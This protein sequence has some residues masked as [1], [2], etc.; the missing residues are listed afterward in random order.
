MGDYHTKEDDVQKIST[1]IYVT[2]FPEQFKARD[3]WRICSQ[4][5]TVIDAFIPNKRSKSGYRFG[6]VCFIRIK[7]VDILV[8]NLYTIWAVKIGHESHSAVKD[9]KPAL[10]LDDSCI[11][12]KDLSLSVVGWIPD[13]NDCKEDLTDSDD[14]SLCNKDK[15]IEN[16]E[17]SEVDSDVDVILKTIFEQG[18]QGEINLSVTKEKSKVDLEEGHF[19]DPFNIY[20]LLNKKHPATGEKNQ[21]EGEPKY[22]PGFTPR[23]VSEVNSN[24]EYN[25][26][27]K[28]NESTQKRQDKVNESAVKKKVSKINSKEDVG[29][30]VSLGHFK[31]V[32]IPKSGGFILQ[33][34]EDLVNVGQTMGYKM[35]GFINNIE[36]IETKMEQVDLFNIKSC[37]G[38]FA[39]DYVVSPSVGNSGGILCVWDPTMFHK[40]HSTVSDYFIAI[41]GKWAPNDKKLLIILVYA[42][43]ELAEKK[44]LRQYLN[45]IINRWKGDVIVM[46]D[47]NEVRIQEERFGS[48][49]NAQRV[50]AFNSFISLGGLVEV[51]SGG[52]LFTW[53]HKSASKMSKLDCFLISEGLMRSCPN[54][55][56][57]TL[58]RYLSDHRPIVLR[59]ISFDYGPTLFC[60]YHYW[61]E[62]DGFDSFVAATWKNIDTFDLNPMLRLLKKL[63]HF[64]GE[65]RLWVKDKNDKN[66]NHKKRLKNMLTGI[67][68]S[69]DKGDVSS[70]ILEERL[71]IMHKLSDLENMVSLELAQKAKIKWSIEGDE[72]SKFFHGIYGVSM[73]ALTKDHKGMKLNTSSKDEVPPKSKN[74][75]PL[76]DKMDDLN[77]TMEEYIRLEEEKAQKRGKVFNWELLSMLSS[78]TLSREPTVSSLNDEIDF[79][80]SFDDSD[81]EDYTPT[82]SYLDDLDFFKEFENEF[83]AIVYDDA[84]TSK[85]DLLTEPI[86]SP[87]H[88]DEFDLND[89]T[90]LS[91]YG[92]EEQNIL[93]FNDLFPLNIIHPDDL[94]SEKDNDNNEIDIIQSSEGNEIIQGSNAL[95]ETSHDKINKTFRTRSFVMNLKAKDVSIYEYAISTLRTEG[96]NFYNI[97]AILAD[98]A[99]MAPLPP[100][101]QRH[102]WLCYQVE[103]YTKEIVHDFDQR[104]ETIFGGAR[105][106]L[107]W[108]QFILALGLHTG[109][110]MESLGFARHAEGMKSSARLS[111]GHF[112]RRLAHHFGL[113]SDDGLRGLSIVAREL[114]L[115]DMGELVKL[116]IYMDLGDDWACV[117]PGPK[118]HQAAAAGAPKAAEDAPVIIEGD[119]AVPAPVQAPQQPPP[120]P[121]AAARTM[122]QRLG[123]L[124]E[125]VQGLRRDVRSL[126]GLVKR[127]MTDQGRFSTWMISAQLMDASGLTYQEFDGTFRGSSPAAF[128][129]RTRQRTGEASTSAA[130]Q[131]PQQPD[132]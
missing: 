8:N 59:E 13:F 124:E 89:E 52:Y 22:P 128:Q 40:E 106:R 51:S 34:M 112:I 29:A 81:D 101:D 72:N 73:P 123:R 107:S 125:E 38:N 122:P 20:E 97:C 54:I 21:S 58:D 76:R 16:K 118:R 36:E 6:F 43:Q 18:E 44:M 45:H 48:I 83:P 103:E 77:I 66:K 129:R 87:Q 74:D 50:A 108:R 70:D 39:F 85:P 47:F 33:L 63:K 60:F 94:N 11:L 57:I 115:N 90:S 92:K 110:E 131:D 119:Q 84:L 100:R 1:S 32:G 9:N 64:K 79:R 68:S 23:D 130:Q 126:R 80:V 28:D 27:G 56:A 7:E 2:N 120:P 31:S 35:N 10:V 67:D 78:K 15:E 24:M 61:F 17:T 95:S 104:L 116:N 65:I 49:F 127:S 99:D 86:L 30:S 114:P 91:E 71:N 12:Q 53:S 42:P 111:E 105:R 55:Y 69:L 14:E 93:Y 88:I 62:I 109:E 46:G 98:F 113:V 117:A 41:M 121:L 5:G 19:D 96:L 102:I 132:P 75:M 3:L 82:V 26:I 37:W 25:S 4:Y